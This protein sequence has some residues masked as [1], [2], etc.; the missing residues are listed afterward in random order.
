MKKLFDAASGRDG[1]RVGAELK[2]PLVGE[3]GTAV[4]RETMDALWGYLCGRG[5]APVREKNT[6]QTVGA[7][8]AGEHN[9]TVASTETGYCKPEFSLAHVDTL[10][11][12]EKQIA[13]LRDLLRPFCREHAVHFLGYGIQP[14]S[15][16]NKSLMA[17]KKRNS[18]WDKVFGSQ[19][20]LREE[21]GDDVCLFTVN[22]ATH[23]HVSVGIESMVRAV[24]VL[25][26]FAPAQIALTANSPVW[27]AA[28]DPEYKSVAEMF[29][30]WWIPDGDRVGVPR[31]RFSD[32]ADY[33]A[34]IVSLRPVYVVRH[35]RPIVLT[36]YSTFS[37]YYNQGRAVGIDETGKEISFVPHKQDVDLHNSCYWFNT[38]ISRYFTVENRAN[39]QQPPDSLGAVAAVTLGLVNA[40]DEAEEAL[41]GVSWEQLR[42][43]RNTAC[44]DGMGNGHDPRRREMVRTMLDVART[45]LKRRGRGEE[46]LLD[47]LY[48]RERTNRCP[49]DEVAGMFGTD[50][51]QG[52]IKNRS[53]AS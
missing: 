11:E 18:V 30:D 51:I 24:N 9:D 15:P 42:T 10:F 37:E 48:E 2:F 38:R 49:A 26:G 53:F 19:R 52:I 25:N 3:D 43:D 40:L 7:R 27:K 17:K 23:V 12:L 28:V 14:V 45:G 32:L 34:E 47:R 1:C 5:W 22:A 44:R 41:A 39:D 16:P 29:W 20:I 33:V 4:P 6:E 50:G 8:I 46:E 13:W 21:E 35:G 31:R 36:R